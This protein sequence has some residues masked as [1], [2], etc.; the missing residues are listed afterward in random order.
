MEFN[1]PKPLNLAGDLAK[2]F[3]EFQEEVLEYFEATETGTKSAGVQIARLKNL[4]GRDAVR[5]YKTL[6]TIKP[7]EETVND[8]LSVLKSHCIPKKNET[9][10]VFNF[11]NRKQCLSEP[12]E[13]F[14]AELRAL[15]TP[16]EFGDQEDKL[17]RAQIILGVN[18]QSIKQHLLREDTTLNKVVEY[19]KSV[20]LAD[21]NLKTIEDGGRSSQSDI[22]KVSRKTTTPQPSQVQNQCHLQ[23]AGQSR[24]RNN[25]QQTEPLRPDPKE[26]LGLSRNKFSEKHSGNDISCENR[27]RVRSFGEDMGDLEGLKVTPPSSPDNK[28]EDMIASTSQ[29]PNSETNTMP[30]GTN[31]PNMVTRSANGIVRSEASVVMFLQKAKNAKRI[32]ASIVHSQFD[33]YGDRKS[34]YAVPLEY[35]LTTLLSSFYQRCGIDP[36]LISYLEADGSGIKTLDATELNAVS[37]ILL[38]NRQSPLLIGSIK[39]NVGHTDAAAALVSV[40]KVLIAMETGRI[41]PNHNFNK[42][43]QQV[44]ALVE[45]KLKVVTETMPWSGGLAAVNAVGLTG[46]VGHILLRSHS[47]EKVNGGLPTDELPRLLFISG[48]TEECLEETFSK[49]E[50]Q[51]VDVECVR[52][53]HDIYSSNIPNYNYRGYTI[54]GT[55][56]QYREIRH[57]DGLNRP[58]WFV[59]SGMGSQWPEMGSNLMKIPII[60]DSIQ[61]SHSIL[62]NKGLDLLDIIT[63]SK[64]SIFDNI[65]HSFVG[66][67]AIQSHMKLSK[68][69]DST[70]ANKLFG[71]VRVL[72]ALSYL[73]NPSN[74]LSRST[75]NI[76]QSDGIESLKIEN[77][78][79]GLKT[80]SMFSDFATKCLQALWLPISNA[81]SER[82]FSRYV[83]GIQ[84]HP[85]TIALVDFLKAINIIPDGYIGHSVGELG[86]AYID[87]CLTAEETILAAYYRGLASKEADLIPGYMAAIDIP[88]SQSGVVLGHQ[89]VPNLT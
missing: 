88:V 61:R 24:S 28:P 73:F 12:F 3:N 17:L 87:G 68:Y 80:D 50:S 86:C 13:N 66:I 16:C 21:K 2:N 22:F 72:K 62:Q 11:F 25:L 47:K 1:K 63:T 48:R 27:D 39:S 53:F 20:E 31:L 55:N 54:L 43:S 32:Y 15:A 83:G 26:N 84:S 60:S 49:L 85:V 69:V 70:G 56:R 7:E 36:S 42:P 29:S 8:I 44:P 76:E 40:V 64:K 38:H 33:C 41:P 59:F 35:P 79:L 34:G 23:K 81:D 19:C 89:M 9:I 46:V 75:P 65:L 77:V 45:G 30:L 37:K 51:P 10:L 52:L 18:S 5:L 82:Y 78:L 14:Y 4:L 6:T 57:Y 67:T 71:E 74:I 58:I